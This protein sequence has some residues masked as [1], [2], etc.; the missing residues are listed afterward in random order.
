MEEKSFNSKRVIIVGAGIS[1]LTAGIYARRSGFDVTILESHNIPGGLSTAWKRKGYLFEGGMHWLTGSSEEMP[2]NRIWKETGALQENNPIFNAASFVYT[3]AALTCLMLGSSY[4][5]WKKSKDDGSYNRKKQDLID[6]FVSV[7]CEFLPEIKS[8][9]EVTDAAT[10]RK[11]TQYLCR[12][13][14]VEF[15]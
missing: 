12:D 14:D 10:V 1:G 13:N 6:R 4:E 11:A 9:I 15:M 3:L 8:K 7:L 2:L 5:Y